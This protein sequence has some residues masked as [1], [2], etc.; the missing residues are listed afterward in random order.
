MHNVHQTTHHIPQGGASHGNR[1]RSSLAELEAGHDLLGGALDPKNSNSGGGG[2]LMR[3]AVQPSGDGQ[4][5]KDA[6]AALLYEAARDND[7]PKAEQMPRPL[8]PNRLPT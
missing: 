5:Q 2:T 3:I 4:H 1:R 7:L 6:H 8:A